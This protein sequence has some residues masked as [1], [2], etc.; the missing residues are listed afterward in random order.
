[1][2]LY[3]LRKLLSE[4]TKAKAFEQYRSMVYLRG[5]VRSKSKDTV[6]ETALIDGE[7]K[8]NFDLGSVGE[9]REHFRFYVDGLVIGAR[10]KV[11]EWM[12]RLRSDGIYYRRKNPVP[13]RKGFEWYAIREQRGHYEG[14]TP[15][16]F[17][18]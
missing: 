6:I 4:R 11:M 3:D 2:A 15:P 16:L 13:T 10:E 9:K 17:S 1:M 14:D 5:G 8:K 12:L 7:M 18:Q